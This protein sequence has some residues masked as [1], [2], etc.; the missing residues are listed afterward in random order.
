MDLGGNILLDGFDTDVTVYFPND[1]NNANLYD[2][3]NNRFTPIHMLHVGGN[4]IS[5]NNSNI[6]SNGIWVDGSIRVNGTKTNDD[7]NIQGNAIN[8][9]G[10]V[11]GIVGVHIV[12]N[13]MD[14]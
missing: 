7:I 2:S 4:I 5:G 11:S 6:S 10:N 1:T 13:V 8:I 9:N 14:S 12:E 3:Y